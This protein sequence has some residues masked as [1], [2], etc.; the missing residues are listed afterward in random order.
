MDNVLYSLEVLPAQIHINFISSF[1]LKD[2]EELIG[3]LYPGVEAEQKEGIFYLIDPTEGVS[4]LHISNTQ[5]G[6]VFSL[7][8]ELLGSI[9]NISES[10][11]VLLSE[12]KVK[13][14]KKLSWQVRVVKAFSKS[15]E[16]KS[17][18]KKLTVISGYTAG[19]FILYP[20]NSTKYHV[21]INWVKRKSRKGEGIMF[22]FVMSKKDFFV[23]KLFESLKDSATVLAPN[24]EASQLVSEFLS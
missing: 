8:G 18:E 11:T 10:L 13:K 5:I 14:V 17:L 3:K 1:S 22:E 23:P 12:L 9:E 4:F 21:H 6:I 19:G 24:A 15:S 2:I 16:K 7:S 20:E